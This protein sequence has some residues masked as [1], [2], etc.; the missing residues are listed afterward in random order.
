MTAETAFYGAS[1]VSGAPTLSWPSSTTRLPK[2]SGRVRYR[3]ACA[4]PTVWQTD[5]QARRT[6]GSQRV[7]LRRRLRPPCPGS[8]CLPSRTR[9][10][11][12]AATATWLPSN[13]PC[14]DNGN[15]C[16]Q[17]QARARAQTEGYPRPC[18]CPYRHRRWSAGTRSGNC[19]HPRGSSPVPRI[20]S[21]RTGG[22]RRASGTG[23]FT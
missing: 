4:A 1:P 18:G 14:Q 16:G 13:D 12:G 17:A 15:P 23:P 11:R 2:P 22:R 3:D 7:H 20:P 8:R 10:G 5:G 9:P 21:R 6:T 19:T